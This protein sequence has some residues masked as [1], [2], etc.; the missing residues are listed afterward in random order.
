MK[1]K[2]KYIYYIKMYDVDGEL[3]Y[4]YILSSLDKEDFEKLLINLNIEIKKN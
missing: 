1:I 3:N 4:D 2:M